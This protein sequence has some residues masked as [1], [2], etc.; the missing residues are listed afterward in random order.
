M[1]HR[2]NS[3]LAGIT[4][5]LA[6]ALAVTAAPAQAQTTFTKS[7]LR[8][9]SWGGDAT[10]AIML[11]MARPWE[12][13]NDKYVEIDLYNG[14]IKDIRD[15]VNAANVKWDVVD[16]EYSDLIQACDEGLLEK[17][18]HTALPAGADGTAAQEDFIDGAL[19]ECGVGTYIWATVYAY[20]KKAFPGDKPTTIADFF[21]VKKFPGKR[22][23]RKDPRG[24]LEWALLSDGVAPG[25]VYSTLAT[26][27][28]LETAFR[29]LDD[30]KSHIVW[31]QTG[32]EPLELMAADQ[33]SMTAV[34]NGRL[35][36]PIIRDKRELET[37]WDGQIWEIEFYGIPKGGRRLENATAFVNFA[38]GTKPLADAT[39]YI[40]YGPVRKSSWPL[41]PDHVK[42][43]LPTSP[44]NM[45]NALR[46]D[47]KWWAANID[48]I[49]ERF[50][51]WISEGQGATDKARF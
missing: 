45:K 12:E 22:G 24:A 16:F 19:T 37:V 44:D 6:F 4:A 10:R 2:A 17:V 50:D 41:V 31:W 23:L 3:S 20:E 9:V 49:R 51:A 36:Q 29:L 33:V 25:E 26:P 1:T 15:Q 46:Y 35:Y 47:S 32:N 39:S 13:E 18:D 7:F 40:S 8:I 48:S 28:G 14:G 43:Y 38:T 34:W 27:R 5:V 30:I 11:S 21:D 42:P